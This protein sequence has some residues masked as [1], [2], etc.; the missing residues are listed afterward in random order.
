MLTPIDPLYKDEH[1]T[2]CNKS[3]QIHKTFFEK[4]KKKDFI[5]VAQ[6]LTASNPVV[7]IVTHE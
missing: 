6:S 4:K 3:P 7:F 1:W 5:G 2:V